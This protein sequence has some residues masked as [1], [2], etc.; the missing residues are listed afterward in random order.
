MHSQWE[1]VK[2]FFSFWTIFFSWDA[3]FSFGTF[4]LF[5]GKNLNVTI[6]S[7]SLEDQK[8]DP[9]LSAGSEVKWLELTARYP[10]SDSGGYDNNKCHSIPRKKCSLQLEL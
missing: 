1:G 4:F 10:S 7:S 3:F 8:T 2:K 6:S 9:Q 5:S